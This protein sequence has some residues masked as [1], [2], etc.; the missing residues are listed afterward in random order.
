MM[1]GFLGI[2]TALIFGFSMRDFFTSYYYGK[3]EETYEKYDV[4]MS[5]SP[6]GRTRFFSVSTLEADDQIDDAIYDKAM[7]FE[8]EVLLE[9]NNEVKNYVQVKASH[10]DTLKKISHHVTYQKD[11]L[12]DEM[13]IT[14]SLASSMDLNIGDEVFIDIKEQQKTF[15]VVDIIK[16]DM[17]FTGQQIFIDKTEGLPFFL[18][19]L[20]A[21]LESL[22]PAL[23][24]NIYNKVY[25]DV[26]DAYDIEEVIQL[27]QS[28]VPYQLLTFNLTVDD[29]AVGQFIQRNMTAFF[30]IISISLFAI[31]F[32]LKTTLEVY[33]NEKKQLYA[34]I[35]I[36]GGK[37]RFSVMIVMMEMLIFFITSFLIAIFLAQQLI[38]Y[39]LNYLGSNLIYSIDQRHILYAFGLGIGLFTLVIYL[40]FKKFYQ[41]SDIKSLN[42]LELKKDD[43]IGVQLGTTILLLIIYLIL[44]FTKSDSLIQ[45][46]RVIL[47]LIVMIYML[48]NII[49][50]ALYSIK[51][52]WFKRHRDQTIYYHFKVMLTKTTFKHYIHLVFIAFLTILLLVYANTYMINRKNAYQETYDIDLMVVNITK[53]FDD[54]YDEIY[55]MSNVDHV[56]KAGLYQQV[57]TIDE[58]QSIRELISI[59]P[60]HIS[61]YFRTNIDEDALRQLN[62]VT[63]LYIILPDRYMFLYDYDVGDSIDIY[64]NG[65]YKE[66]TFEIAG[67]FEK[68]LGDLAFTNLHH[69][70]GEENIYNILLV[71]ATND[72]TILKSDLLNEYHQD[73]IKVIDVDEQIA[74]LLF[75]MKKVTNYITF[76]LAIIIFCFIIA[77]MN[78]SVLL[79]H[80]M[81]DVYARMIVLGTTQ[82]DLK[83][84]LYQVFISIGIVLL[85]LS[86]L[87][88]TLISFEM[89]E[90]AIVF[91]EFEPMRF[92]GKPI[93]LGGIILIITFGINQWF[94]ILKINQI[95]ATDI[96]KV[97]K[98]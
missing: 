29:D 24:T 64:V 70:Y 93:W 5:V 48:V 60:I 76:I 15:V 72:K 40:Y 78:H 38:N 69:I 27:I 91:G 18:S 25:I 3:L 7:F 45:G 96:L 22:N 46:Y 49:K 55:E 79:Y 19:A 10:I 53:D 71:N 73:L 98:L 77:L 75:E 8:F 35:H 86:L 83:H 52:Y 66:Q 63:K 32:V 74:P 11:L 39:G 43:H 31:A 37:K 42:Q 56:A 47:A 97:N 12:D 57:R 68:Q 6:L 89:S 20:S 92:S 62:K 14:E 54:K 67:F 16:D 51:R 84:A 58:N 34:T 17:L 65:R 44:T 28:K 90:L 82:K 1:I 13:I 21:S 2:F 36:L 41:V 80:D 23:L 61:T 88:Y 87:G 85:A 95:S 30:M 33:F 50:I 26:D 9:K 59:D 4:I 81:K 94:Y